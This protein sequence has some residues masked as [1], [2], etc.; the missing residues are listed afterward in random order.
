MV[1]SRDEDLR[2]KLGNLLIAILLSTVPTA[3][4]IGAF[5]LHGKFV[6]RNLHKK[7][8][9]IEQLSISK[10]CNQAA[11]ETSESYILWIGLFITLPTWAWFYLNMKRKKESLKK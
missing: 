11:R 9:P 5:S 8:E 3:M 6:C 10:L 7:T 2:L 1:I 4:T